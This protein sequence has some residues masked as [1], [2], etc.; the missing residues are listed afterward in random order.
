MHGY[1]YIEGNS[2]VHRIDPRPKLLMLVAVLLLAVAGSHPLYELPLVAFAFVIV[3]SAGSIRALRRVRFLLIM[4]GL[5][6]TISWSFFAQGTT[7]LIGPVEWEAFLYGVGTAMKLVSMIVTSVAFLATTKNEAIAAAFIRLGLP[8]QAAFAFSTALR[9]VPTFI[10]AGA[11]IVQAQRSR[12]LDVESGSIFQRLRKQIPLLIPVFASAI[13][14][15]NQMAMALESKGFG[16][17]K[18]RTYYLELRLRSVDWL[19]VGLGFVLIAAAVWVRF[20]H[21]D[22]GQIPGLLR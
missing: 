19:V 20:F 12:G 8:F 5:F 18:E 7:P 17:R 6:S 11:T 1:L 3:A 21:Q 2:F 9:L 15:T 16:A 22:F 10:G 4:V 13:R 14:N